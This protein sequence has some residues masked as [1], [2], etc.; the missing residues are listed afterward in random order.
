MNNGEILRSIA[1]WVA[2]L[3]LDSLPRH[4]IEEAKNQV[5]GIVAATHAGHFSYAG[6]MLERVFRNWGEGKDATMI[7]S[8]HRASLHQA[9]FANVALARALDYDDYLLGAH[10]GQ[11][12]VPVSLALGEKT[13]ADGAAILAA[14][15]AADEVIGRA[16][17]SATRSRYRG[18][19]ACFAHALGA[20]A[21]A[22]RLLG[23][24]AERTAAALAIACGNVTIAP[25]PAIWGSETRAVLAAPSAVAG[26]AAAE[27]AEI[28][29]SGSDRTLGGEDGYERAILGFAASGLWETLGKLWLTDTLS[30]C[31]YPGALYADSCID[32][33]VQ[34]SREHHVD[35]K[36]VAA[37]EVEVGPFTIG[38]DRA[39]APWIAGRGTSPA[40]LTGSL[41]FCIAAA[42]RDRELSAR[43]FTADTSA[44]ENLWELARRVRIREAENLRR[45][46][47]ANDWARPTG[48]GNDWVAV[49]DSAALEAYRAAFGA[50][51]SIQLADGRRFDGERAVPPAGSG[52]PSDERQRAVLDKFRRETRYMLR[53]E[54]M[55][56]AID[57]A[58]HLDEANAVEVREMIRS[59]CTER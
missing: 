44:D 27:L 40:L 2:D 15:I 18:H 59:A 3:K 17:L 1:A 4:V 42:L 55:E 46:L 5:A 21:A 50:R 41:A 32:L 29:L 23:L 9:V 45:R 14:Q 56:R 48:N 49:L 53:K 38:A 36:K 57:L 39:A 28:G 26:V 25:T 52:C 54:R 12:A 47:E 34:L 35:A 24:D 13:G 8:G 22:A 10:A 37:V 20:A 6:R 31:V 30:H 33:V 7:P 58:L 43:Q 16:G 19:A 51:V 11:S